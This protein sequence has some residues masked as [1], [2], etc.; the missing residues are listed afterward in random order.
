MT[1]EPLADPCDLVG[2]WMLSRTIEDRRGGPDGRVEGR[3]ELVL[4]SPDRVAWREHGTWHRPDGDVEV[5]RTLGVVRRDGGWWVVFADGRD[6]HP[7][8]PGEEVVHD[9]RP[10]TYRGVVT[11]TS[12]AWS[13]TWEV[14]GPAKDYRMETRLR[15]LSGAACPP[16]ATRPAGSPRPAGS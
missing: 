15:P 4:E 12:V 16:G 7:W 2:T 3:L 13:V 6:F 9:C 10:D 14:T 8:A 11:G 5:Q 1:R